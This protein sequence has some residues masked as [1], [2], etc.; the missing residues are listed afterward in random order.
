M[1]GGNLELIFICAILPTKS[2]TYTNKF[3]IYAEEIFTHVFNGAMSLV[4]STG[5]EYNRRWHG[6]DIFNR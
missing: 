2:N 6:L 1:G 5:A 3:K 4:G